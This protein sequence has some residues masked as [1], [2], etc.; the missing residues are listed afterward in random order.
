MFYCKVNRFGFFFQTRL[1]R[2]LNI[3][4]IVIQRDN[5][6]PVS[7]AAGSASVVTC[8]FFYNLRQVLWGDRVNDA[9]STISAAAARRA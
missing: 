7:P 6:R 1:R 8:T 3:Y 5:F 4:N 9:F 2:V